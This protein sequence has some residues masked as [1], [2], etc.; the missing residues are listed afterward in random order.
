LVSPPPRHE[1]HQAL[2]ARVLILIFDQCRGNQLFQTALRFYALEVLK[3]FEIG[4]LLLL[5]IDEKRTNLRCHK[6]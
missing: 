5:G 1:S 4:S 2:D 6:G 3:P